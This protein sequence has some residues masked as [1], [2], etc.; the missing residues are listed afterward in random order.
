MKVGRERAERNERDSKATRMPQ[1]Y[2][3]FKIETN[4]RQR[5][6][7]GKDWRQTKDCRLTD[8]SYRR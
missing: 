2:G 4:G 1:E 7:R 3:M 6:T 8:I 5:L